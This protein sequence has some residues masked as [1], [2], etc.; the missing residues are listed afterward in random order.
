[1]E[2]NYMHHIFAQ[3]EDSLLNLDLHINRPCILMVQGLQ[4]NPEL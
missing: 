4:Y 2:Y 3:L 1:M